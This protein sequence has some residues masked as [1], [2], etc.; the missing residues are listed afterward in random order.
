MT[1]L[2]MEVP[3]AYLA[4]GSPLLIPI[5]AIAAPSG[6]STMGKKIRAITAQMNEATV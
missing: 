3:S 6:P 1:M 4:S 2:A 5:P